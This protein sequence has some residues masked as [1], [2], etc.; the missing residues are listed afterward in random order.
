MRNPV[1]LGAHAN[2][3]Q[4]GIVLRQVHRLGLC[5]ASSQQRRFGERKSSYAG[6]GS[7]ILAFTAKHC[8]SGRVVGLDKEE[9]WLGKGRENALL[10]GLDVEFVQGEIGKVDEKK[11]G[12]FDFIIA[13]LKNFGWEEAGENRLISLHHQLARDFPSARFMLAGSEREYAYGSITQQALEHAGFVIIDTPRLR[14]P[15]GDI[16]YYLGERA[17]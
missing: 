14:M 16:V 17:K 8:G 5:R 11:L 6:C 10:N 4:T 3:K 1:G 12:K 2:N 9:T 15:R 13:N 7:G